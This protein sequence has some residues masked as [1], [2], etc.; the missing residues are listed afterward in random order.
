VATAMRQPSRGRARL[1]AVS[2]CRGD[3]QAY[4]HESLSHETG[5]AGGWPK[6]GLKPWRRIC[7]AFPKVEANCRPHGRRTRPLCRSTRSRPAGGLLR[8]AARSSSSARCDSRSSR[9]NRASSNATIA[10]TAPQRHRS[11]CSSASTSIRPWRKVKVTERRAAE[12]YAHCMRE[13]RRCPLSDAACIRVVQ[14]NLSTP[15]SRLP[16]MRPSHPPKPGEFL[17][18]LEFHYTPK[19][20]SWLNMV[21]IEIGVLRGPVPR[22]QNRR[23]QTGSAREI[24]AWERQ[25][26]A[27]G[28]PHQMDCSQTDK[29]AP[30]W[31]RA[32]PSHP[33]SHNHCDEG[34]SDELILRHRALGR[35]SSSQ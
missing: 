5:C 19:H 35:S 9:P 11:I 20:A 15:L 29:P 2:F 18:R 13:A 34:T 32:I 4:R 24:D 17:R 10:S 16:S 23:T 3:G 33:K 31:A 6:N 28:R 1:D 22:P 27:A 21:E 30:K 7:G 14:D 12:D 25:R 26:N 8:R